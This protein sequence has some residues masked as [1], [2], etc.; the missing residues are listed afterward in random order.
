MS[1]A[2]IMHQNRL[3]RRFQE[4]EATVRVHAR[5]AHHIDCRRLV[6]LPA[7]RQGLILPC[8]SG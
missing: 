8:L 6:R 7:D 4:A 2:V 1:G 5:I 3:M